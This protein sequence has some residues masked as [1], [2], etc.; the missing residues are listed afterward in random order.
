[1]AVGAA[2][3]ESAASGVEADQS[4]NSAPEAGAAYLFGSEGTSWQQLAFIKAPNTNA[5][6][7]FGWSVSL[8]ADAGVLAIGAAREASASM[9]ESGDQSDNSAA[10][11]GAVYVYDDISMFRAP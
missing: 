1:M 9:G 11:A 7:R 5:G 4:N 10:Q 3:E 6:D 2:L 8:S